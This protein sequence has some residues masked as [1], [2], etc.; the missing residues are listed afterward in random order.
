[1]IGIAQSVRI[2]QDGNLYLNTDSKV[3]FQDREFA[4]FQGRIGERPER[5]PALDERNRTLAGEHIEPVDNDKK[6]RC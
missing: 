2:C 1:M 6:A 4:I 5:I 3:D